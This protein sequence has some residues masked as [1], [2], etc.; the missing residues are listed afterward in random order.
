MDARVQS[1]AEQAAETARQERQRLKRERLLEIW[2]RH[3]EQRVRQYQRKLPQY[4][5]D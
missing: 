4:P 1:A 3:E 2:N 5:A